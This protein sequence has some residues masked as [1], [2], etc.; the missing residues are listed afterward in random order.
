MTQDAALEC[1][2]FV[3]AEPLKPVEAARALDCTIVEVEQALFE[4]NTRLESSG[5][6]LQVVRIAEGLQ[7]S[8]RPDYSE[9]IAKL[10]AGAP[11]K[12]SRAALETIAI[13]AYQQPITQP[14]VEAIRGVS[15]GGVIK[16]L[17]DR[18][19]ITEAG[20]KQALGRPILYTTT[21]DFLHYF[22]LQDL[23]DLPPLDMDEV[24]PTPE[25]PA[26]ADGSEAEP[27]CNSEELAAE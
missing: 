15:C 2:L 21:Q 11:N 12:L 3:S 23:T 27:V 26:E 20:R 5:S 18:R 16:T 24:V 7:L 13:I 6:G 4:L 17:A 22:A 19:L 10:I 1:L 8:T 25:L 9:T 14:E